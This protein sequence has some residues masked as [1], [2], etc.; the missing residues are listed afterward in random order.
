[1]NTQPDI[2]SNVQYFIDYANDDESSREFVS[3]LGYG[4]A[5]PTIKKAIR[6]LDDSELS[7]RLIANWHDAKDIIPDCIDVVSCGIYLQDNEIFSITVGEV[8]I[9]I[10][11][12]NAEEREE[13]SNEAYIKGNYA[14][15]NRSYDRV[16]AILNT[17][18]CWDMIDLLMPE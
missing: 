18:K 15:F 16:V 1:M 5:W 3:T 10:S 9:D 2:I 4:E 7:E 13:L 12:L 6:E 14:Y 11:E 8:E 17:K